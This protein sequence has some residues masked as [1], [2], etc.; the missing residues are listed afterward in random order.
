MYLD[1]LKLKFHLNLYWLQQGE[2][3]RD[4]G[5]EAGHPRSK[6]RGR[7]SQG[8]TGKVLGLHL[9]AVHL[10][11]CDVV[12]KDSGDVDLWELILAE[13]DEEAG[14]PTGP[15]SDNHQLLSDCSHGWGWQGRGSE[16]VGKSQYIQK[17]FSGA[18]Q[19]LETKA[20]SREGREG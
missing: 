1:F 8:E 13:D 4:M 10:Y 16:N 15:I 3:S 18:P 20:S 12:L 17:H 19:D 14:L 11:V 6:G 7:G 2:W 9:L 5:G